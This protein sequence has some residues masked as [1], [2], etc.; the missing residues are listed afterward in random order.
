[1]INFKIIYKIIGTLL[2]IEAAMM[3]WCL[4]LSIY[5]HEKDMLAFLISIAVTVLGGVGFRR[6]GRGDD[7]TSSVCSARC[8]SC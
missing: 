4:G 6:L 2:F 7:R 3:M 1:M 8:P 5:L